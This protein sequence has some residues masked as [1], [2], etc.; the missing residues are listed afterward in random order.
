M[1]GGMRAVLEDEKGACDRMSQSLLSAENLTKEHGSGGGLVHAVD[2]VDLDV[3]AGESVAIVGPSGCGKSS[4]LYLLGGLDRPTTGSVHLGAKRVD[5]LSETKLARL[6]RSEIGFVFQTFELI[7]ELTAV[8][9]IELPA[10]LARVSPRAARRRARDLL[11]EVGLGDRA[12]H[13]PSELSGGQRQRVAIARAVINEPKVILADEPT[14][15]LDSAARGEV[16]RL[17]ESLRLGGLTLVTVTH[18]S[19][20][21]ATADRVISMRDGRFADEIGLSDQPERTLG[22]IT[23]LE[24]GC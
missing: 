10:L 14:G 17:F 9:N 3:R 19:R 11:D 6:R 2:G 12:G 16:L 5:R 13:L 7:E 24:P 21:A 22:E 20:I 15:S 18:D 23:G 8:E 4:L 1:A